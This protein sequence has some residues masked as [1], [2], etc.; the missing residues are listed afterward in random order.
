MFASCWKGIL[1]VAFRGGIVFGLNVVIPA[2]SRKVGGSSWVFVL[3]GFLKCLT[4]GLMV[5]MFPLTTFA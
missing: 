2:S 1:L 5:L 4:F 3:L